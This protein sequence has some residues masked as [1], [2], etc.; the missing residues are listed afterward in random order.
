MP[1]S[2]AYSGYEQEGSRFKFKLCHSLAASSRINYVTPVSQL[3][4][5]V[6]EDDASA[7]RSYYS[8]VTEE[9]GGWSK[10]QVPG[11]WQGGAGAKSS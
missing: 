4:P 11:Q 2:Q 1:V 8:W 6:S 10:S 3:P 5:S 7:C 9:N